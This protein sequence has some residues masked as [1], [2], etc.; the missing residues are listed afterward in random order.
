MAQVDV[1]IPCRVGDVPTE[2]IRTIMAGVLTDVRFIVV[3]DAQQR[4]QAWAR[5]RGAELVTAPLVLFSDYD[6]LWRSD[7]LRLLKLALEFG[8]KGEDETIGQAE[9][10]GF[11]FC[12]FQWVQ[13]TGEV[14]LELTQ[15]EWDVTLLRLGPYI[16]PMA[17]WST[18]LWR[19][20]KL[21]FD[22]SL[23]RLEDWDLYLQAA[24]KGIRGEWTR[25][26][27]FT[28]VVK[29]GISWETQST[30]KEAEAVVRRKHGI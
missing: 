1:V 9:R 13:P 23:R 10:T 3:V 30:F 18:K 24:A 7:A 8:M 17:L 5:N 15:N 22:E 16:S 21:A 27:G 25:Q 6:I 2:T 19:E 26:L 11:A 29:K 14:A 12:Q 28:T 20:E 4:G